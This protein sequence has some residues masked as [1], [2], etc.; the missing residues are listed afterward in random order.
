MRSDVTLIGV[1]DADGTTAGEIRYWFGAR[2]GHSHCSLCEITHG[3]FREKSEWRVTRDALAIQ[4]TTFHRNDAPADVVSAASGRFPVV[5]AR[6]A[7][8]TFVLLSA[9][10]L[11][12]LN[13][14][15]KRFV[16]TLEA[17]CVRMGLGSILL[18]EGS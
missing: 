10:D 3:V 2:F 11:E 14:D 8:E 6:T 15:S 1:Y 9:E 17:A 5:V 16:A 13:G 12:S 18:S 7:S 4:F